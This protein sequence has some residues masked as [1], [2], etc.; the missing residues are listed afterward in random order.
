M[1]H[2]L[3]ASLMPCEPTR[4]ERMKING[5]ECAVTFKQAIEIYKTRRPF[6]GKRLHP[7]HPCSLRSLSEKFGVS[8]TTIAQIA[9]GNLYKELRLEQYYSE[10][11]PSRGTIQG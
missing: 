3:S 9:R 11:N 5:N 7:S 6:N 8:M 1:N 10:S 2:S 4:K